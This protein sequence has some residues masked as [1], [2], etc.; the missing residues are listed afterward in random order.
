MSDFKAQEKG[1]DGA[2]CPSRCST[3][4]QHVP[5]PSRLPKCVA[6]WSA[7]EDETEF[8]DGSQLLIAVPMWNRDNRTWRYDFHV[9]LVKCDEHY[10]SVEDSNGEPFGWDL[11]EADF[12]VELSR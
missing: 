1:V 8:L 7:V 9:V 2:S 6:G 5:D 4:H 10:F 11:A 12:Y 3:A